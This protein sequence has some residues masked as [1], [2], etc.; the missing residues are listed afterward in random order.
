M[1]WAT[2]HTL[3][4]GRGQPPGKEPVLEGHSDERAVAAGQW[5]KSWDQEWW[6]AAAPAPS[7]K[8]AAFASFSGPGRLH[9]CQVAFLQPPPC[10]DTWGG[11][12]A[13]HLL[14]RAGGPV[15]RHWGKAPWRGKPD[16]GG[17]SRSLHPTSSLAPPNGSW[18]P[19]QR[20]AANDSP[21]YGVCWVPGQSWRE[22][23]EHGN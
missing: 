22:G 14:P 11:T 5:P 18:D 21:H 8:Q 16:T 17:K 15:P 13:T 1:W 23:W 7:P 3:K 6:A 2:L 9:W 19:Q 20:H 10:P 4:R 12:K